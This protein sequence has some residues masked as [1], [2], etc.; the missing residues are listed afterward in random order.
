MERLKK[1]SVWYVITDVKY[2]NKREIYDFS[3]GIM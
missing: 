1:L 3:T 2:Y